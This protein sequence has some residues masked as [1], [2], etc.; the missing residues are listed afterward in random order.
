[1]TVIQQSPPPRA[2]H[3]CLWGCLAIVAFAFLPFAGMAAYS[4]WFFYQGYTHDPVLRGVAELVRKDGMAQAAL[5]ENIHIVGVEGSALS[6]VWGGEA[7]SYVVDLAGSKAQGSLHVTASSDHGH[8]NV[9]RMMLETPSGEYDLL[10]HN[11]Q[12]KSTPTDSI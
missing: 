10:H 12:Q 4:A 5:G 1:M 2:N 7:G 8:L 3:G 9:E 11:L 6:Y